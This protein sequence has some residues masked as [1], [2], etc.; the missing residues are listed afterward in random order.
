MTSGF[1]ELHGDRHSGDD[2]ALVGGLG[3]MEG[4]VVMFIGHQKGRTTKENV[5]RNFG[6][7]R[8]SGHRKAWRLMRHAEKFGIP[9]VTLIDTPGAA[10][11]PDSE[12]QGQAWAI[13]ENILL[14]SQLQT[15]IVSAIIGEGNSGGAL[16][17]GVADR[18]LMLE[19]SYF[20]VVS[21]EGCA[22]ILWRDEKLAPKA[23]EAMRLTSA[24]ML[25]FQIVDRL[26]PEAGEGAH[27]SG[28][29]TAECLKEMLVAQLEELR[30]RPISD[31][32]EARRSKY[33]R[34][35]VVLEL[36]EVR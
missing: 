12:E 16:A 25:A 2:G 22:T 36:E 11:G 6:G 24:D 3:Q 34:M 27:V 18:I 20:S 35:G 1:V 21:P 8:P 28:P 13:A 4:L 15:P 17:I 30:A 14:M 5:E 31:L 7:A 33:R 29:E 19:N 10:A 23:A 26:V 9:V 32:L